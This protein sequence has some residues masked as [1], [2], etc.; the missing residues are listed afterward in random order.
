MVISGKRTKLLLSPPRPGPKAT[1]LS[2]LSDDL[3]LDELQLGLEDAKPQPS[4]QC[5]PTPGPFK[6]CEHL[7]ESW[8]IRLAVWAIVLLSVLCNGLVLL[9]VFASGPAPLPPVKF[10]VGAIAGSN[11]LTGISCGLLASVDALTFGQFA[12]YG[13]R[14]EVGLGCQATGFLADLGSKASMLLLTLAVMQ[15]SVSVSCVQAYRKAPSLCSVRAGALAF[16]ML[17]VPAAALPHTSVGVYR[18]S[19]PLRA[20]CPTRGPASSPGLCGGPG[21]DELPVLPGSGWC[22]HQTLL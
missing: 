21:D 9:S 12:E 18:T 3:D 8:G 22:L 19:P 16:L 17:A 20:L 5:S 1:F 2:P 6:P 10:V 14:W 4:V 13:A 15:C 11:T 7:F